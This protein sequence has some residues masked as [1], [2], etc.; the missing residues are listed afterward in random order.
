[1][2]PACESITLA[3]RAPHA[4]L[5]ETENRKRKASS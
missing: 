3:F 4:Y 1:L 2:H 5:L